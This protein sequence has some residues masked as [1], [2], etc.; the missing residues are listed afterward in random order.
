[1]AEE[2]ARLAAPSVWLGSALRE[3]VRCWRYGI[4]TLTAVPSR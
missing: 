2:L 4:N 1:M 3:P